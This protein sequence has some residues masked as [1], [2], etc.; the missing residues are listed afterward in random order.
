MSKNLQWDDARVFLA[1]ARTGTLTRAAKQLGVGTATMIRRLDRLES[2][3]GVRLFSRHQNGYFLTDEGQSLLNHAERLEQAG[4]A[5]G[6]T[7]MHEVA[8]HV[9]LATADNLADPFIIPALGPLY[10]AHPDLTLELITGIQTV[11]L[12]RRDADLAVRMVKPTHGNV[13][14]R[15]IGTLGFG[16]YG[17]SSYLA[18][19]KVKSASFA[20]DSDSLIGWAETSSHLPSAQWIIRALAGRPPK[21]MTSSLSSQLAAAVAGMGLAVLPHFLARRH[22]LQCL[23]AELGVNQQIW[24]VMH[25]DLVHSRRIRV[26]ADFLI[27]LFEKMPMN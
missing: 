21:L 19:R 20:Q 18:E 7:S 6:A 14:L 4:Q 15:T 25:S 22:G 17:S 26:V 1:L 27:A 8:G 13:T 10:E 12:H 9:R 23:V 16:L 24:L 11:N 5:F 3:L 2:A